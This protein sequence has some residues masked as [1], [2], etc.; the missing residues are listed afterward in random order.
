MFGVNCD[1]SQTQFTKLRFPLPVGNRCRWFE[2]GSQILQGLIHRKPEPH[3]HA[4]Q[5]T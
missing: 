3:N 5:E 1:Q 4:L 2:L